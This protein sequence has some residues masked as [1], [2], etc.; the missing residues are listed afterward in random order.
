MHVQLLIAAAPQSC[1][2]TI[3]R[4]NLHEQEHCMTKDRGNRSLE[5]IYAR[6]EDIH[7]SA[8]D[9]LNAKAALAQADALAGFLL[10]AIDRVKRLSG[11]RTGQLL[12][13]REA[14]EH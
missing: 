3:V 7:M 13:Q 10:G 4:S 2:A 6:L 11:A 12:A 9:R 5:A 14:I 8:A 1:N